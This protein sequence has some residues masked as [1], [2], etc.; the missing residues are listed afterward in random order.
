MHNEKCLYLHKYTDILNGI[1]TG[2]YCKMESLVITTSSNAEEL[3]S[4]SYKEHFSIRLSFVP[5]P[6]KFFVNFL[7]N[8]FLGNT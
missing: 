5:L 7:K 4:Y 8:Y 1:E 6:I 2:F 3:K